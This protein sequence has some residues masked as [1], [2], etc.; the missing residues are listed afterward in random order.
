MQDLRFVSI[1][2]GW[3]VAT[4]EAG[5][6]FRLRAD[7]N[8]RNALRPA[9]APRPHAPKVPPRQIQQLIRAGKTVAEVVTLTGADEATVSRFEG[10]VVAERNYMV[11]Q[12]RALPVRLQRQIDP[13]AAEGLTF[14]AAIDTRLDELE[15]RDIAWDAWK[16]PESGWHIGLNF[17]TGDVARNALWRYDPRGRNLNPVS[18]AAISLS[19][20]EDPNELSASPQLR[21]VQ[22]ERVEQVIPDPE[23]EPEPTHPDSA[24]PTTYET[25]DLLEALRKRRG[26]RQHQ[27]YTE[28]VEFDEANDSIDDFLRFPEQINDDGRIAEVTPFARPGADD[29]DETASAQESEVNVFSP[30]HA[31]LDEQI[32]PDTDPVVPSPANEDTSSIDDNTL[33]LGEIDQTPRQD[34]G[35]VP[36]RKTGRPVMP[37]WDEIVFGTRTD[38]E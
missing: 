9:V 30:E 17:T 4:N 33:D 2:D 13:L 22:Q 15:A 18:A 32:N 7:E 37:T 31:H 38:D 25:A 24:S 27:V 26:E 20:Q 29:S 11:E 35:S 36:R 6:R 21:A 14:G 34:T 28:E 3:V 12:A 8:L 19:Q 1:E 5:E 10:P 16:D 23:P